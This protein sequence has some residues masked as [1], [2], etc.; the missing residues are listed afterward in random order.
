[1]SR[2]ALG[3]HKSHEQVAQ[4]LQCLGPRLRLCRQR[5]HITEHQGCTP[6]G[7]KLVGCRYFVTVALQKG[8]TVRV[9]RPTPI[10]CGMTD[11]RIAE[12]DQADKSE[13]IWLGKGMDWPGVRVQCHQIDC[14]RERRK[15]P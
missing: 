10:E 1:M 9:S 6:R 8:D 15:Y 11:V 2:A 12:I 7:H 13:G 4:P 3:S 5:R 14:G